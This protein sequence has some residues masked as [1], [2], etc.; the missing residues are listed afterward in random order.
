MLNSNTNVTFVS[1]VEVISN[2][3][4]V[5]A[6]AIFGTIEDIITAKMLAENGSLSSPQN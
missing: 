1:Q 3:L 5:V 6:T 4:L 2:G